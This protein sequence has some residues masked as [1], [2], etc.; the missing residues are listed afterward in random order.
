[1]AVKLSVGFEWPWGGAGGPVLSVGL[2]LIGR[3][4]V[5]IFSRGPVERPAWSSRLILREL[6][7]APADGCI[8]LRQT[9][10]PDE[11]F[12]ERLRRLYVDAGRR[13]RLRVNL[14]SPDAEALIAAR[15]KLR[16]IS[17]AE[18]KS[19]IIQTRNAFFWLKDDVDKRLG[20]DCSVDLEVRH[21]DN[22][23]CAPIYRVADRSMFLGRF[24]GHASSCSGPMLVVRRT[25]HPSHWR[26]YEFD[27]RAAWEASTPYHPSAGRKRAA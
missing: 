16:G 22:M 18:A 12:V 21:Y 27:L 15:A 9:W 23:P 20:G 14:L 2:G 4:V 17:L 7:L 13:F 1:V 24:L 6:R 8:W 10:L 3:G 26:Q 11:V 19:N 25:R 5:P